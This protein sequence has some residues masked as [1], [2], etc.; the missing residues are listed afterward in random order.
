MDIRLKKQKDFDLVFNKGK[1]IYTSTHTLLYVES[2]EFKFGISLSKK[3]GKAHQRNYIK[4]IIRACVK[5]I[6][7]DN[8]KSYHVVVLP[9]IN[10]AYY[11]NEFYK[12]LSYS[13]QK[14]RILSD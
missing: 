1:R 7:K 6:I 13:L 12:D 4:R 10:N 14:G 9:K 11:Y 2:S 5:D 3:H 8:I